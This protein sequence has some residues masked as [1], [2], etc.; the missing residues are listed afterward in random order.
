MTH[1]RQAS[2]PKEIAAEAQKLEKEY[3]DQF[4]DEDELPEGQPYAYILE[5]G[6]TRL[7]EYFA[8]IERLYAEAERDGV[9]I[10]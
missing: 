9:M 1:Y 6:S 5:N 4:D 10:G 8:E 7:R 3:L 2:P